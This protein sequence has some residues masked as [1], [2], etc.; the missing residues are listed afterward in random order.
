MNQGLTSRPRILIIERDVDLQRRIARVLDAVYTVDLTSSGSLAMLLMKDYRYSCIVAST[1]LP[2]RHRG[3]GILEALR[4]MP[5][6]RYVPVV[7]TM[8]EE[9]AVEYG[10]AEGFATTV[11]L[12]SG[13]DAIEPVIERVLKAHD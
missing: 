3:C 12:P 1:E 10:L 7:A 5:G 4:G 11:R 9:S 2:N 8:S 13:I 6:G